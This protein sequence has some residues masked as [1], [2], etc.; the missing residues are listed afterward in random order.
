MKLYSYWR[1][2]TSFR[3]RAALNL[4][5]LSY[6]IVPVDLVSGAQCDAAYT[7]LNPGKG[8]PT[9]VLEDGTVLTQSLAI[10]DYL[11]ALVQEPKLIPGDPLIRAR[12]LAAAHTIAMDVHPVNN[13]RVVQHLKQQFGATAQQAQDWMCHWMREGFQALETQLDPTHRFA[14]GDSP[15]VADLCV[16][17][18]FYNARRWGLELA[19]YPNLIRVEA[20][21]LALPEIAAAHPEKQPDAKELT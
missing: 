8:V 14:F 18:Q 2:T 15:N 4:K 10:I 1:S 21:C 5:G 7:R 16:V 12:V 19:P 20:A 17:A 3:V 13:L 6:D 11:D 9:L